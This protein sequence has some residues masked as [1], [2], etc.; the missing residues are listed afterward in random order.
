M[1]YFLFYP[2]GNDNIYV[3]FAESRKIA[4][5]ILTQEFELVYTPTG[6]IS[7]HFVSKQEM[8]SFC[9]IT[10]KDFGT[11]KIV[12]YISS[13]YKKLLIMAKMTKLR[14]DICHSLR[15]HY[16]RK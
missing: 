5:K 4:E 15:Y 7:Y 13:S 11:L 8:L 9:E 14:C 3:I 6:Y 2:V 16:L 1:T 10:E 12:R